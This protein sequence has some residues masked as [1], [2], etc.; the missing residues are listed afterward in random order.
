VSEPA[1]PPP[2]LGARGAVRFVYAPELAHWRLSEEHP[3]KPIRL[4]LLRDLL[5]RWDLLRDEELLAPAPLRSG[6]LARVHDD[7]YLR[8]V[9]RVSR[10]ERPPEAYRYGLG[11]HD[12]PAADGLHEA[13]ASVCAATATAVQTV[14]DG[15][16]RR[17]ASFAGGLHHAMPGR[18]SGFCVYDDLAVAILRATDRGLRVAYLDIDAHHGD[19]VQHAFYERADVLTVSLHESGRYLFPG[20]G[21]TYELGTGEGRGFSVNLP[22]EPFTEDDSYLQAFDAV[23]APALRAYEPDL[24]V[25]QAGADPHRDDPLADLALSLRGLRAVYDRV[26]ALADEL[27]EGRLVATGG[28]GYDA[29]GVA[30]RAWAQLWSAMTGRPTPTRT[31]PGW[32]ERWRETAGRPLPARSLDGPDDVDP[33]PRRLLVQGHNDAVARRLRKVLAPIWEAH[34][35]VGRGPAPGGA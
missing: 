31:P 15:G 10:G 5:Q 2:D 9:K 27:C 17:A 26:V 32:R 11:T 19:G 8:M 21:H 13:V 25:L 24:I 22:L 7:D 34:D 23:A 3:F 12:T 14:L 29:F 1:P 4:E 16:A 30:P 35:G 28:G 20:T 33:Q 18:A 6:E